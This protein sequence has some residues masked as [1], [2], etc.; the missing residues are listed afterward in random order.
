MKRCII[1]VS[2][3]KWYPRGQER[4]SQSISAFSK[5]IDCIFYSDLY[6]KNCPTHEQHPYAFKVYAIKDA[7]EQNYDTILWLDSSI[8]AIKNISH[9]FE[10]IENNNY[11]FFANH[12]IG[13]FS[14]DKCLEYFGIS[15]NV[16]CEMRE[17]MGCCIGLNL[18]NEKNL[19]FI[20]KLY[21]C[22]TDGITFPG[23]WANKNSEASTDNRVIGHRHDQTVMSILAHKLGMND[24]IDC[25][26]TFMC[27]KE[28]INLYFADGVLPQSVCL[29]N[30]GM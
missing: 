9:V 20:E 29:V 1:N 15:R 17:M 30:E 24:F 21:K 27:Y 19:E 6:P 12:F 26:K 11:L 13:Y 8:Y 18:R 4:L 2:V 3:G 10:Y 28:H 7:I 5:N 22:A 16:A 23:A 14:T 25:A